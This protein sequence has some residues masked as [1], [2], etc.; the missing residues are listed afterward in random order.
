MNAS[1]VLTWAG[2]LVKQW[3]I[4]KIKRQAGV[5]SKSMRGG[6]KYTHP[7]GA[8][9]KLSAALALHTIYPRQRQG[10]VN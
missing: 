1:R 9:G 8:L 5:S 10:R 6:A 3:E 4:Q 2:L 7:P